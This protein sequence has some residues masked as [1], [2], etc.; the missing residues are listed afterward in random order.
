MNAIQTHSSR[1]ILGLSLLAAAA[2]AIGCQSNMDSYSAQSDQ[3]MN[4]QQ[5][6]NRPPTPQ[7]LYT[8]AGILVAQARDEEAT[9]VLNRLMR[10]YPQFMPT[11]CTFAELH[12]RKN[13][14]EEAMRVLMAGLALQPDEA[15]LNNDMGMC[16]MQKKQYAKA[17]ESFTKATASSSDARY[18]ANVAVALGLLGREEESMAAFAQIM[19]AKEAWHNAQ[20]CRQI[21]LRDRVGQPQSALDDASRARQMSE[22]SATTQPATRPCGVQVGEP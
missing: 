6:V 16:W 22:M 17:L 14:V 1:S 21:Y 13:H 2:C 8:M 20:V 15:V 3:D 4:F 9:Y 7:T 5:G 19:P 18:R 11:Y 12:M 10:E